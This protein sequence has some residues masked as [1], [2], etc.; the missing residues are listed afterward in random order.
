MMMD[1]IN[2][3]QEYHNG[4]VVIIVMSQMPSKII[5]RYSITDEIGNKMIDLS[6]GHKSLFECRKEAYD[7]IDSYINFM[8]QKVKFGIIFINTDDDL[9]ILVSS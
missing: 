2:Y 1:I 9:N 5:Y 4:Y 6:E 8:D 7:V 3:I